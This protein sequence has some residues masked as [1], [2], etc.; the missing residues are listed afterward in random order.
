MRI[1][2]DICRFSRKKICRILSI[3]LIIVYT[4]CVY[5]IMCKIQIFIQM[6]QLVS[7]LSVMIVHQL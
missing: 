1:V 3:F 6:V 2:L 7:M 5:F 4:R